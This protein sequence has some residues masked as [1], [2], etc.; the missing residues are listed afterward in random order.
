MHT[1]GRNL[2]AVTSAALPLALLL[3]ALV[4]ITTYLFAA[5]VFPAPPP[6]TYAGMLVDRQYNLTLWIM[7]AVFLLAQLCLA[8]AVFRFRDRG[9]R[10]RYFRSS[11]LAEI[12]WTVAATV[13]FLGLGFS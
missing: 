10:A 8:F 7:G 9:Q 4:G 3:L 2:A 13:I 12:F 1:E 5:R 11:T 6:I